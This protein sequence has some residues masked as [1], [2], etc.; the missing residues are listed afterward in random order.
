MA[1]RVIPKLLCQKSHFCKPVAT[2]IYLVPKLEKPYWSFINQMFGVRKVVHKLWCWL[3]D[4]MFSHTEHRLVTD[5][6]TDGRRT[7]RYSILGLCINIVIKS[8]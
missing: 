8:L 7:P 1:C 3:R 2:C 5:R 4:D 6:Q